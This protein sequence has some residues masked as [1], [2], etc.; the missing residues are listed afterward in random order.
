MTR[1]GPPPG[2][3][4]SAYPPDSQPATR[5]APQWVGGLLAAAG[6][7]TIV[8]VFLT[9]ATVDVGGI[10][11]LAF[12]GTDIGG[13]GGSIA[14]LGV[15]MVALGVVILAREGR[16]WVGIVGVVIALLCVIT[17]LHDLADIGKAGD[18]SRAFG[19]ADVK[20]GPGLIVVLLA[21]WAGVG[22]SIVAIV[23]RRP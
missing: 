4:L 21:G 2:E 12:A 1:F 6:A 9:W 19:G 20:V 18:I 14:F 5:R 15:L 13:E 16:L 17:A 8:G 22:A 7:V 11:R 23:V 3:V 10:S